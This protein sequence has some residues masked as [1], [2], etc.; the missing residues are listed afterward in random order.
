MKRLFG[1]IMAAIMLFTSTAVY[2]DVSA[3]ENNPPTLIYSCLDFE[4]Q[5]AGDKPNGFYPSES[6]NFSVVTEADNGNQ[7]NKAARLTY[8]GEGDIPRI[9]LPLHY[10]PIADNFVLGFRFKNE[11]S[12]SM[13][14][15]MVSADATTPDNSL[16]LTTTGTA[17]NLM[18]ISAGV[19]HAGTSSTTIRL[20]DNAWYDI[21]FEVNMSTKKMN[22]YL[23]DSKI[24]SN[25]Q[26][27][28]TAVT[29]IAGLTFFAPNAAAGWCIDDLRLYMGD[30]RL[31]SEELARQKSLYE[32]SSIIPEHKYELGRLYQYDKFVY[33][34]L[35]NKFVARID[36]NRFYKDNAYHTLSLPVTEYKG[37]ISVPVRDFA[38]AFGG[39]YSCVGDVIT[40]SGGGNSL[41]MTVGE[42]A[43]YQDEVVCAPLETLKDFFGVSYYKNGDLLSFGEELSCPYDLG[44]MG[45][46]QRG[47][48]MEEE[49]FERIANSLVYERPTKTEILEVFEQYNP[50]HS[51]P[52]LLVNNFN[53][54]KNNLSRDASYSNLVSTLISRADN[55]VNQEPV[56]YTKSDGLRGDFTQPLSDRGTY[57]SF[58]YKMTGEEK[59]KNA[60]WSNIEAAAQFPD[61][62]PNHF[63]DVGISANGL[64]FAYDWMADEWTAEQRQTLE[65]LIID[66]VLKP[67]IEGYRSPKGSNATGFAYSTGNQPIIINCG[68]AGCT[69]ALLDKYPDICSEVIAC[70]LR[71]IETCLMEF[72]PDG[73]WTEGVAYWQDTMG[74]LPALVNIY[75]T[76][77]GDD[78]GLLNT[79]GLHKSAYFPLAVSGASGTFPMGD[80]AS[81]SPYHA[82]LMW[83]ANVYD[84][85]ALATM[86]KESS[87]GASLTDVVN[88][89]FDSDG[90]HTTIDNDHY[91]RKMET[92]TMRT[93]WNKDDTAI[94]LHGGQNN[95]NHGHLDNGTFQIDMLGERWAC[96][97]PKE[98]Y[99]I[100]YYGSYTYDPNA[101]A[102]PYK[103]AD[104]YR[105]KGEGHNTVIANLGTTRSD[106]EPGAFA[107]IVEYTSTDAGSFAILDMT[108]TNSLYEDAKRGLML[109]K[110][111]D[112]VIIQDDFRASQETEFW[113]FMHTQ[114][115]ITLSNNGK[116]V[117][118]SKNGKRILVSI[119]SDGDGT[120]QIMPAASMEGYYDIPPLQGD[121]S[122]YKKTWCH[123]ND[124]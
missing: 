14:R 106:Q 23:N 94:I 112:K 12:S 99:N 34:T 83:F 3:E 17:F 55:Y 1:I 41:Q 39:Q 74:S 61:L 96:E 97:V 38:E 47:Y 37:A 103:P 4:E 86:R 43:Y 88:W 8:S 73:A 52:R 62:N 56:A 82:S 63:L 105:F 59:Y 123:K 116:S 87:N 16:Y 33:V 54:I 122:A 50:E 29:N 93:G 36:G 80:D 100:L 48:T 98:E 121:N 5:A 57:L 35:Y 78:F 25:T 6:N 67:A 113:W 109:D 115:S 19:L 18:Y 75:R 101:P 51:Y 65:T 30:S 119:I 15:L 11:D 117:I 91:F 28:G 20:T 85:K 40:I 72:A 7:N 71:S 45:K 21:E 9:M 92:A 53:D 66:K 70:S 32:N 10:A 22:V 31:S 118:L 13:K 89:V 76:A 68:I 49:V 44:V 24:I 102:S 58:A 104:Y 120:F 90:E 111:N 84:D 107:E 110:N 2:I 26:I 77:L 114:A 69:L 60:L 124:G 95:S 81:V 46:N 27:S 42:D 79:P 64:K 108:Q